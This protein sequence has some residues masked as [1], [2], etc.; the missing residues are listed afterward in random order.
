MNFALKKYTDYKEN[1]L[2]EIA[3]STVIV[4]D[5]LDVLDTIF[6]QFNAQSF[7]N[8]SP[9]EQLECINHAVEYVQITH[10]MEERFMA[11]VKRMKDAYN[12][13]SGGDELSDKERDK[14]HFYLAIRSVLRKR[15]RIFWLSW[16]VPRI[17]RLLSIN[18]TLR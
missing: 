3:E 12:L 1:D 13:C 18:Q 4:R 16:I 6:R 17:G 8:G 14:I 15:E 11:C 2:E 7:F 10:E 9:L 5:S